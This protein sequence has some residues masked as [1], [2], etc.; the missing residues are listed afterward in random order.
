M[1]FTADIPT[2]NSSAANG[3]LEKIFHTVIMLTVVGSP[4]P[5]PTGPVGYRCHAP[6]LRGPVPPAHRAWTSRCTATRIVLSAKPSAS[7]QA[8]LFAARNQNFDRRKMLVPGFWCMNFLPLLPSLA[9]SSGRGKGA[10]SG[11]IRSL[12]LAA[13]IPRRNRRPSRGIITLCYCYC[14]C[15]I[16]LPKGRA[17]RETHSL[18]PSQEALEY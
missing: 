12:T 1:R 6:P 11:A 10:R 17:Q 3:A 16:V 8:V 2:K 13:G 7:L 9:Q 5:I 4:L 18:P 15:A 14:Y